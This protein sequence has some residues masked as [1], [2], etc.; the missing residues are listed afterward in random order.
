MDN[1]EL[2]VI[3]SS[4][5]NFLEQNKY[6][7]VVGQ[8]RE[9]ISK[10]KFSTKSMKDLKQIGN[11]TSDYFAMAKKSYSAKENIVYSEPYSLKEEVELLITSVE[12]GLILPFRIAEDSIKSL[13]STNQ[14]INEFRFQDESDGAKMTSVHAAGLV[15]MDTVCKKLS[16]LLN[17]LKKEII[18]AN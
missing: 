14:P 8:W 13:N 11:Y 5:I 7:W 9:E 12:E 1:S 15:Q 3:R 6:E 18:N 2:L 16:E 17:E 10:G 4:L